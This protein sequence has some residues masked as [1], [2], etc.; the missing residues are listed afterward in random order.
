MTTRKPRL[1]DLIK[2]GLS[3]VGDDNLLSNVR[4]DDRGLKRLIEEYRK[5]SNRYSQYPEITDETTGSE[6]KTF[7]SKTLFE[8]Q[9]YLIYTYLSG[10]GKIEEHFDYEKETKR[11][12]L[13]FL[14]FGAYAILFLLVAVVG[15]V[16]TTGVLRNDINSDQFISSFMSL[17]NMLAEMFAGSKPVIE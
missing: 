7:I 13:Q 2:R 11:F 17:V 12:Y 1:P 6:L 5:L 10:S 9:I 8:E 16:V 4:S 3:G 14:K 15:G